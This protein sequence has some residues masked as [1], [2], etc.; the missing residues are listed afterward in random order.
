MK[1]STTIIFT[2]LL[3][4]G[5]CLCSYTT[6]HYSREATVTQVT[7]SGITLVDNSGE[8]WYYENPD[9]VFE[10][11]EKIVLRM[12]TNRTDSDITDDIIIKVEKA[13]E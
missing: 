11:N 4:I 7:T 8:S 9:L 1:K 6:T 12:N 2:F 5:F 10:K 13:G 3:I